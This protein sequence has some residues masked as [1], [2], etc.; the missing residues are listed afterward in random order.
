MRAADVAEGQALGI[1]DL[2]SALHEARECSRWCLTAVSGLP[3]AMFGVRSWHDDPTVGV[4]WFLA[5]DDVERH[6]RAFMRLAPHY[7]AQMLREFPRLK[8]RVHARNTAA[9]TWL[10]STGFTLGPVHT[11]PGTGEP[12]HWFTKE[13]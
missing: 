4:P 1:V 3:V 6:R 13:A 5:T 8:N 2:R 12:F 10:A 9:V 11:V 7:I